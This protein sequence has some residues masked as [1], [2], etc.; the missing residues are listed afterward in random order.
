MIEVPKYIGREFR[1]FDWY[2]WIMALI[3]C[4]VMYLLIQDTTFDWTRKIIYF[5]VTILLFL[6]YVW[7]VAYGRVYKMVYYDTLLYT[8]YK[9]SVGDDI[10]YICSD[11]EEELDLYMEVNYPS[12]DYKIEE[13]LLVESYIKKEHFQ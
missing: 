5:G 6:D 1:P 10:Y 11:T 13:E 8:M 3:G 7:R 12:L 2:G 4:A 9:V